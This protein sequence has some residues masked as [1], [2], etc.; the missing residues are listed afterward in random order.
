LVE[1]YQ[2]NPFSVKLRKDREEVNFEEVGF[3]REVKQLTKNKLNYKLQTEYKYCYD[4]VLH[5]VLHY[6][7]KEGEEEKKDVK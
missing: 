7:N 5:Y 3:G 6:L 2:P 4:V 1:L